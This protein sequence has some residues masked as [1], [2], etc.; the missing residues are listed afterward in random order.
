MHRRRGPPAQSR[1]VPGHR[2]DEPGRDRPRFLRRRRSSR[3]R[4]ARLSSAG[5]RA[6]APHRR[7]VLLCPHHP[8]GAR[9]ALRAGV[10]LP[11]AA[12][13]HDAAGGRT[14]TVSISRV[15]RRRR[16]WRT[17]SAAAGRGRRTRHARAHRLRQAEAPRRHGAAA[18]A[19]NL[20]ARRFLDPPTAVKKLRCQRS[21]VASVDPGRLLP[22]VDDFARVRVVVLRR[23]DRRRVHLRRSSTRVSREAP[24]L[25][26]D[27]DSTEIVPGGAGNAANNVAALG[28]ARRRPSVSAGRDDTGRA[29]S[30]LM[31]ARRRRSGS[32]PA[33][34]LSHADQDAHPGRRRALGEAAGRPHRPRHAA[35]FSVP[36]RRAI[37][38]AAACAACAR[39]DARARLRLRHRPGRRRRSWRE[40]ARA[41]QPQQAAARRRSSTRAMRCSR[42]RGMTACTPNESEVEHCSAS[43]SARMQRVLEQAGRELLARTRQPRRP[44]SRAAAAA[45]RSSS[46]DQPTITFPIFGSDRDRRRHRRRRYRDRDDD[47][48][49]RGW[50]DV[51]RS[52]APGQL[53]RRPRRH[54]TRHR[55]G[56][57]RR[58]PAGRA[59]GHVGR[60][61]RH[62]ARRA[63]RRSSPRTARPAARIAF[64]N[65]CF[66][67]LHVGH[68]RYLQARRRRSRSP[69]RRRERR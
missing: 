52:R 33:S 41:L 8:R 51:R 2:R 44:R 27:Y 69:G 34:R 67:L 28:G 57:R 4:I 54:E 45:W 5:W 15:V 25:I 60:H 58:A 61:G 13:R 23:P 39:A 3:R 43:A 37:E 40:R 38:V 46:A 47:A 64:A 59:V 16:S 66:D 20:M 32:R 26:L 29:C 1:R 18:V 7:L 35:A 65:G 63:R 6:G 56:L 31:R 53:R 24:V 17:I 12:A 14:I 30:T 49:A 21:P 42:F 36:T 62:R 55:D 50:R 48:G 19:D 22:L 11:Q 9:R 10:R 68:V